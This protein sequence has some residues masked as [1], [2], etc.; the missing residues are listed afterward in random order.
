MAV[1]SADDKGV[2][3]KDDFF[4]ELSREAKEGGPGRSWM[5]EQR[6][7]DMETFGMVGGVRPQYGR[8]GRGR[9]GA[10]TGGDGRGGYA[11]P[12]DRGAGRGGGYSQA[13][14]GGGGG[15][16]QAPGRGGYRGQ[17]GGRGGGGGRE[18]NGKAPP[19]ALPVD[20]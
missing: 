15:Y 11:Q 5:S 12:A 8:G 18:A 16:S 17:R 3:K 6:K 13:P 20:L 14:G 1:V 7:L 2:Y 19:R 10:F 4:D 9:R